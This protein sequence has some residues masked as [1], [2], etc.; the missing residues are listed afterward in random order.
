MPKKT[1]EIGDESLKGL[2]L[3]G[4][5]ERWAAFGPARPS[6]MHLLC[7]YSQEE[8]VMEFAVQNH[9][10]GH[11]LATPDLDEFLDREK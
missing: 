7:W 5:T 3:F 4:F 2:E 11:R 9:Q 1:T 6:G 8:Q 10:E